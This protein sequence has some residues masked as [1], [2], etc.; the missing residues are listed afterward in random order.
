[1]ELPRWCLVKS[2]DVEQE[3]PVSF[4]RPSASGVRYNDIPSN[5]S[6]L[7]KVLHAA[8]DSQRHITDIKWAS[9]GQS[10]A[11]GA[12]DGKI[13]VYRWV[14]GYFAARAFGVLLCGAVIH[15]KLHGHTSVSQGFDHIFMHPAQTGAVLH[16]NTFVHFNSS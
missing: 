16:S 9:S 3:E 8:R 12:A 10:L 11:M 15:D 4:I 6:S 1:M 5:A 13:Y 14:A 2:N 7:Q